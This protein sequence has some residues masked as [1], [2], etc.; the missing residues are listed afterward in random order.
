MLE[1]IFIIIL[2]ASIL[3]IGLIVLRKIPALVELSPQE[4]KGP[5]A[6]GKIKEKI[7]NNKRLKSFSGELLLQKILSKIRVLTLKTENKTS[8]WLM[9]LRQKNKN[10]FSGDYWKKIRKEK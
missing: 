3:G 5:G 2:L 4:I 10:K 1:L 7:K 9:R 8:N 6:F